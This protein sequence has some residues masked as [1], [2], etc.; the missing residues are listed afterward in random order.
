LANLG[1]DSKWVEVKNL[2]GIAQRHK[3][4]QTPNTTTAQQ[5]QQRAQ[6]KQRKQQN[7]IESIAIL[8]AFT[9]RTF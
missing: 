5:Q 3:P 2:H 9:F 8:T 7:N 6:R 4:T 1:I